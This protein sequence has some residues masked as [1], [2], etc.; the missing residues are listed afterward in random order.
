M[1]LF[2]IL[3]V[4]HIIASCICLITGAISALVK[5]RRGVH[6]FNGEIYHATFIVILITSSYMAILHWSQ[7]AYLLFI[8]IFSYSF[9][10]FGYLSKKL[11]WKNWLGKHIGGMLGSYI[12]IL[13]ALLVVN[14]H[15]IP[16]IKQFPLLI[17]WFLPTIIGTPIIFIVGK[18]Y[19]H[20][21]RP[22]K[23]YE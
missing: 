11:R 17:I 3:L 12:A 6:T 16:I 20:V 8:G 22:F 4:I 19:K 5:K 7:S 23:S 2:N 21:K 1:E 13:T 9:A 10:L 18:R 15:N 14:G